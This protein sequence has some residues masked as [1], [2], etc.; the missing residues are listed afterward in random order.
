MIILLKEYKALLVD[1]AVLASYQDEND[2]LMAEMTM[3]TSESVME[4]LLTAT[5]SF[6]LI[7]VEI[8][9]SAKVY[10]LHFLT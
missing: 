3:I 5:Y 4:R 7:Q 6:L 9:E 10:L 2:V 1:R 8:L